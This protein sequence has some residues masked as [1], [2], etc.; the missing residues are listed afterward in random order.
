MNYCLHHN[1]L[2]LEI[3]HDQPTLLT[4]GQQYWFSNKNQIQT[5]LSQH[6]EINAIQILIRS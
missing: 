6:G 3:K 1:R 4:V 2:L 5:S